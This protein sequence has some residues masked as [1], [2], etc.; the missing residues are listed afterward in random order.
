MTTSA[1]PELVEPEPGPGPS[2][3]LGVETQSGRRVRRPLTQT[4]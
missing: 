1:M 2:Y 3:D 4:T